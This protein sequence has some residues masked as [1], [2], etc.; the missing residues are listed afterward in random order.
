MMVAILQYT[1]NYKVKETSFRNVTKDL[2]PKHIYF[3]GNAYYNLPSPTISSVAEARTMCFFSV[4]V[5]R[6]YDVLKTI[7]QNERISYSV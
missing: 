4:R 1:F 2:I 3:T 6:L 5:K 7:I